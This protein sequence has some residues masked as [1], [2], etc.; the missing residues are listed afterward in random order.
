MFCQVASALSERDKLTEQEKL[1]LEANG[2]QMLK[3][4]KLE[5]T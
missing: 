3:S 1:D 4:G 5:Q 2:I